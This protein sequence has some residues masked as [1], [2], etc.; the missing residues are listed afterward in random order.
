VTS[1]GAASRYLRAAPQG[2]RRI[3]RL[4][5]ALDAAAAQEVRE[6]L[7]DALHRGASPLIID[8]SHVPSCDAAGLAV[9]IGTQ[10]RAKLLGSVVL[11]A[12]PRLLVGKLLRSA[13]LH[14]RFAIYPD[15]RGAL[16]AQ[17]HEPARTAPASPLPA[18]RGEAVLPNTELTAG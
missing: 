1:A 15:V 8:L 13:G 10:R 3:V 17:S 7:L 14:R 12:A 6:R 5:G 11:L 4:C 9:L 18:G 2:G 16:A